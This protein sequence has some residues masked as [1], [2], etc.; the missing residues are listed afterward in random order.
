MSSYAES[1]LAD[2]EAIICRYSERR[3]VYCRQMQF[4]NASHLSGL[5]GANRHL[6]GT[7]KGANEV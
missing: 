4:S 1:V 2:G 5:T 3:R 7:K 6:G